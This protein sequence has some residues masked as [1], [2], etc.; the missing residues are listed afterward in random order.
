[1][2]KSN[3]SGL[4]HDGRDDHSGGYNDML[5]L[6]SISLLESL[7]ERLHELKLKRYQLCNAASGPIAA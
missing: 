4:I 1:M 6:I 2:S 7:V 3:D 5:S